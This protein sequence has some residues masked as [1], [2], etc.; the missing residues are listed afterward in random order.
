[1]FPSDARA[2]G[3]LDSLSSPRQHQRDG[4]RSPH[5]PLFVFCP[6]GRLAATGTSAL[7]WSDAEQQLPICS[8]SS[9]PSRRQAAHRTPPTRS[10]GCADAVWTPLEASFEEPLEDRP[11]LRDRRPGAGDMGIQEQR[12]RSH[13]RPAAVIETRDRQCAFCGFAG[14]A[15]GAVV[16]IEAAHVRWVKLGGPHELDDGRLL[17]SLHHTLFDR[18]MLRLDEE[19][20]LVVSQRFSARTPIGRSIDD[21]HGHRLQPR[22]GTPPPAEQHM[23]W[24]R[25]QVVQGLALVG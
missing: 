10:P 19:M 24:R 23:T 9:G 6:L 21:L 14:A 13:L 5:K 8:R 7:P 16:G 1:M 25:E 11:E 18:G 20:R 3:A 4:L 12:Q 15:G 22:R 17:C 2:Q